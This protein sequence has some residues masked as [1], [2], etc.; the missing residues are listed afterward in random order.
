[1]TMPDMFMPLDALNKM[2][3]HNVLA[4]IF[5]GGQFGS[6]T[7]APGTIGAQ[8][9]SG[10]QSQGQGQGQGSSSSG[11]QVSFGGGLGG[12]G[13]QQ[14]QGQGQGQG[15]QQ[16]GGGSTGSSAGPSG[17]IYVIS[18]QP[19]GLGT[20]TTGGP[21]HEIT[22][23]STATIKVIDKETK[24]PVVGAAVYSD[25]FPVGIT[26]TRGKLVTSELPVGKHVLSV[27]AVGYDLAEKEIVTPQASRMMQKFNYDFEVSY[28]EMP[29][30]ETAS[31]A[32]S[33]ASEAASTAAEQ[34]AAAQ[35]AAAASE[36]AGGGYFGGS[37]GG[38]APNYGAP[39]YGAP[40]YNAPSYPTAPP[41]QQ[42]PSA[43]ALPLPPID[44]LQQFM[45]LPFTTIQRAFNVPMAGAGRTMAKGGRCK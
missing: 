8:R 33:A 34:A 44:W 26:D 19:S 3:P 36:Y 14:Q 30:D 29:G 32:A 27:D 21:R 38:G 28:I 13:G 5:S 42:A 22:F 10:G 4:S 40:T 43:G 45:M 35:A 16:Q 1:M 24:L 39:S 9:P 15:Q 23:P 6:M 31:E 7:Q 25:D 2:A 12:S 41:A 20:T 17:G 11:Q 18:E 37:Y